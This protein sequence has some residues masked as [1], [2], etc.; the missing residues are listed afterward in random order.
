MR[1]RSLLLLI[2]VSATL[3]LSFSTFYSY[4]S[5]PP[6][7]LVVTITSSPSA[8]I[9]SDNGPSPRVAT[10][11]ARVSNTG[12]API[13]NLMVFIGDG[14]TPGS[15]PT[16]GTRSLELLGPASDA[17][18]SLGVLPPGAIQTLYWFVRYPATEN[19]AYSYTVWATAD[20]GCG[21]SQVSALHIRRASASNSSRVRP[22][23]GSVTIEPRT[24][25]AP[26]ELVTVTI[27]GFDLG[28][29]GP[30]PEAVEDAWLQP[31]SNPNFDPSCLRL[32]RTEVRFKSL[33]NEPYRDQLYF[34]GIASHNPPPNYAY[35]A[36]DY[37]KYTFIGL[38]RCTT[39]LQPYQQTASG[40][41]HQY[42]SDIGAIGLTLSVD[43]RSGGLLI[44]SSV[45]PTMGGT[46][47]TLTYT[48]HYGNTS[49]TPLG[50][51]GTP[52]L[53]TARLPQN[54]AA[55][56]ANSAACNTNCLKLWSTDEGETFS[57]SEPAAAER[58]NA[59][60]WILLDPVPAGQNPAGTVSFQLKAL[61]N[62]ELCTTVQ[63]AVH[64][65]IV[66]TSDTS[67]VNSATDVQIALSSSSTV[68]PGG[69]LRYTITYRNLGPSVA[70][71]VVVT[72]NLPADVQF[73]QASPPPQG[74]SGQVVTYRLG[75]LSPNEGGSLVLQVAVRSSLSEGVS[76]IATARIATATAES[77]TT[78]NSASF[79][80]VVGSR[81]PQLTAMA[82]VRT[83]EDAPPLGPSSNDTLEYSVVLKNTGAAAATNLLFI[84]TPDPYTQLF[85]GSVSASAGQILSGNADGDRQIRIALPQLAPNSSETIEFRV[86]IKELLS[87]VRRIRL[88]GVLSCN[89]LPDTLTDD[90]QTPI[91]NDPTDLYVGTGPLLKAWKSYT[92]FNDLDGNG[93][94]SPGDILKYTVI[95][96]NLGAESANAVVL[97]EGFDPHLTL[98]VGSVTTTQGDVLS[99]NEVGERF[100][101]IGLGTLRPKS[102]ITVTY[103]AG[104][105]PDIPS[106]VAVVGSQA[107]LS[108]ANLPSQPS[109]DPTTPAE[110]DPTLTPVWNSPHIYISQRAYL[111][112]DAN[113]DGLPSPGDTLS[114]AVTLLN[115]GNTDAQNAFFSTTPDPHTQLVVGSVRT[116]QGSV[117]T[118]NASSDTTIGIALDPI[119][120]NG[121]AQLSFDVLIKDSWP[122]GVNLVTQ[123]L[124][125]VPS[126]GSF[127]SDDPTT[128]ALNDPTI[129]PGHHKAFLYFT[130]S[131]YAASDDDRNGMVS[132]GELLEY[133]LTVINL[134]THEA[135]GLQLSDALPSEMRILEASVKSD[136]G[137]IMSGTVPNSQELLVNLGKLAPQ[138][139]QARIS[140]QVRLQNPLSDRTLSNQA[141]VWGTNLSEQPSDDP[142][143][144]T[145]GDATV[146][147]AGEFFIL[148]GDVDTDGD[149]D[150]I[151]A[152]IVGQAAIG[153]LQLT[154]RQRAAADVAPPFGVIDSRDATAIA[155]I[156]QGYRLRCPVEPRTA[157]TA[158]RSLESVFVPLSVQRFVAASFR[159]AVRFRA[160]GQGIHQI[161]VKIFDLSGKTVFASDWRLGSELEWRGLT[162]DGR[163]VA[164]GV[165]LYLVFVRGADGALVRSHLQKLVILR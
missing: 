52:L 13:K 96:E 20:G 65:N 123:S 30:G 128:L 42:N 68:R 19:A 51:S 4:A 165:Y 7:N 54:R 150:L 16:T 104:I 163:R 45:S 47:T 80:T 97:T 29:I 14:T 95:V 144:P 21:D 39:Q 126:A 64:E 70:E 82:R 88:Q 49:S 110:E 44:D 8:L 151:D 37:V 53:L 84:A 155:E 17:R 154:E 86:R 18:R 1:C 93:L 32:V 67:C 130:K 106:S 31:V 55:Y 24:T 114:Y 107:L 11:T 89:E 69:A 98:V 143:T 148:C 41:G 3:S 109:D 146:L 94:P 145:L 6:G 120:R 141:F 85:V 81:T 83:L 75:S 74:I 38:R 158:L 124:V 43:D 125:N 162:S 27:T 99:G 36:D 132:A 119:P 58:V 105:D 90:P 121:Q 15:F 100:V 57:A 135:S 2:C 26:G 103:R 50:T 159:R 118:G 112:I 48:I 66:I 33:K 87:G 113:G 78:N 25:I 62:G 28:A 10:L 71:D 137:L 111:K 92:L 34:S 152:Q 138:G 160:E 12:S 127:R 149:V 157:E 23:S 133:V 77:E 147:T 164:N 73:V 102:S 9:G 40:N 153:A 140:F 56:V 115:L 161:S 134:G 122:T 72:L 63:G 35:N 91:P 59:I 142:R 60:R 101:R 22:P 46:N 5:C 116:S 131:V 117:T 136:H 139:G 76:L 61:A 108:A 79:T 156:A 129:I